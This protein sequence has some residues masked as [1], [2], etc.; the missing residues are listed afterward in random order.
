[1]S[2]PGASFFRMDWTAD[3]ETLARRITLGAYLG[4]AALIGFG[5]ILWIAANWNDLGK[6]E[7]FMLVGGAFLLSALAAAAHQALRI[8]GALIA[9]CAIGGLFAL[10]GQVYQSGA[11][12]WQLFALWAVLG[13]PLA[14]AARHDVVWV[15]W[16]LV[17][18][19][20]IG[21]WATTMGAHRIH[22]HPTLPAMIW[23]MEFALSG[24][25]LSLNRA[26]APH[27]AAHWAFRLAM[28]ST[29]GMLT[30]YGSISII[31]NGLV[32]WHVW[33]A[34]ALLAGSIYTFLHVIED[35]FALAA[36][37]T[38]ALDIVLIVTLGRLMTY[39][40]SE[41]FFTFL[42]LG[43]ISAGIV[44]ASAAFLLRQQRG[45]KP[46][47]NDG[48]AAWVDSSARTWPVTALSSFG[49]LMATI[50]FLIAYFMFFGDLMTKK[51]GPYI[52]GGLTLAAAFAMLRAARD[53]RFLQQFGFV[54]LTVGLV[55][56]A[57]GVFR[58]LSVTGASAVLL[59]ASIGIAVTLNIN[60]IRNSAGYFGA[61]FAGFLI[62]RLLSNLFDVKSGAVEK[63]AA[64]L[65]A[66]VPAAGMLLQYLR[67][68]DHD[69]P[70]WLIGWRDY[71]TGFATTALVALAVTA[72]PSFLISAQ[73]HI[74]D[75]FN[76][77]KASGGLA[78]AQAVSLIAALAAAA[79]LAR[80]LP[81]LRTPVGAAIGLAI[82]IFSVISPT[83]GPAALL[84]ALAILTGRRPL[85]LLAVM[86]ALSIIGSFYY[87]LG[88]PLTQKAM[89]LAAMGFGL[90]TAAILSGHI[91]GSG[92]AAP[93]RA[94]RPLFAA[95]LIGLSTAATAG[96]FL[97]GF[98]EKEAILREGTKL[99]LPLAPV[100][101]RSLIQ[102]DYMALRFALPDDN[103][104][105]TLLNSQQLPAVAFV[106]IDARG[107]AAVARVAA[108]GA[109]PAA[110]ER[111]VKLKRKNGQ[112]TI[113][114]D[115]WFFK[116]GTA[117]TFEAAKFGEFRLSP[118][119]D[120][121]L[122]GMAD[123]ALKPL[124]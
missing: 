54:N 93:A 114:T 79:L 67:R 80:A 45:E 73:G 99:Y 72:G 2:I 19:T 38:L 46:A 48:R 40:H 13:L 58:D 18:L 105:R 118:G 37:A 82:A 104:T 92:S 41:G 42:L 39:G 62:A 22:D 122:T 91:T 43:L 21:L 89:T 24:A 8:P 1:M 63:T 10:F 95:G 33:L 110:E 53:R 76:G 60:W 56:I 20:G 30:T 77:A 65:L 61:I 88:W 17:V 57:V 81:V 36:A 115:A 116:E 49:A 100:D 83:L 9:Y 32:G 55:L 34:A 124:K 112:W 121:L 123:E 5:L 120:I 71:M 26:T 69:L 111:V 75:L 35:E 90:A 23:L 68:P 16:T 117:K 51:A 7:R 29:F 108:S 96:V 31:E 106:T 74:G 101:P 15:P 84:L 59:A 14:I 52:I 12:P 97:T 113:G 103:A 102:G 64:I 86:A 4:A 25:L 3:E 109:K 119:G 85:A 107:V 78:F 28:I 47:T 98:A 70:A 50:P 6:I 27:P 11:D 87:W 66:L 44:A 94:M